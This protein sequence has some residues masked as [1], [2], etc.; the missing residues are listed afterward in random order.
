MCQ[1]ATYPPKGASTGANAE[2]QPREQIKDRIRS[3]ASG[4]HGIIARARVSL[5]KTLKQRNSFDAK[6]PLAPL[7]SPAYI[8]VISYINISRHIEILTT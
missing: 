2:S 3:A 4:R 7:L 1:T 8:F 5:L 6:L